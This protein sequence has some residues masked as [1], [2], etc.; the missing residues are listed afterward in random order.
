MQS[1]KNVMLDKVKLNE[2][3]AALPKGGYKQ[4]AKITGKSV[5]SVRKILNEPSRY[6]KYVISATLKVA[7]AHK[8]EVEEL[9]SKVTQVVS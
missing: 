1:Q 8:K 9:E 3:K 5:E 2:L 6:N 7:A 4:V